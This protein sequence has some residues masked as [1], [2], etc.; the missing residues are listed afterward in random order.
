MSK[1][2]QMVE[3]R[4][5]RATVTIEIT[6]EAYEHHDKRALELA[7]TELRTGL[8]SFESDPNAPPEASSSST[9]ITLPSLIEAIGRSSW[10]ARDHAVIAIGKIRNAV[11]VAELRKRGERHDAYREHK[12][13]VEALGKAA[14]DLAAQNV[15]LADEKTAREKQLASAIQLRDQHA[16]ANKHLAD[17]TLAAKEALSKLK[18]S[19]KAK[20]PSAARATRATTPK[21][22]TKKA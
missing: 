5:I 4:G 15:R 11:E 19:K 10:L 18:A 13:Q 8:R 6:P 16:A 22:K 2:S 21:G 12:N 1:Y 9:W 7:A 14:A 3:Q 20:K 17:E